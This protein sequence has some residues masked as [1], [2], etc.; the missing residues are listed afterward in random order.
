VLARELR[1]LV[2]EPVALKDLPLDARRR[3]L[4]QH[5][6]PGERS[7]NRVQPGTFGGAPEQRLMH[8]LAHILLGHKPTMMFRDPKN[9]LALRAHNHP[10]RPR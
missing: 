1:V 2:I 3:L 10:S 5:T 6:I 4:G 8:E 7:F 9:I